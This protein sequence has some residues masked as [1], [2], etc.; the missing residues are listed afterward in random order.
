MS[1]ALVPQAAVAG[2]RPG[3]E[4]TLAGRLNLDDLAEM[5]SGRAASSDVTSWD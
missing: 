5:R 4:L 3:A 2:D 1:D